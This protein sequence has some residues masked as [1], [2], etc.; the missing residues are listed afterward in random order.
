M[1]NTL[2]QYKVLPH[3]EKERQLSLL[4]DNHLPDQ[5]EGDTA[6]KFHTEN[7]EYLN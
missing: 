7:S 6:N 4:I 2:L 1:S 5:W 3:V